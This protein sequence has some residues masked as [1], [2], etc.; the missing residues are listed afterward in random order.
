MF[1]AKSDQTVVVMWSEVKWSEVVEENVLISMQVQGDLANQI[2][3]GT[4]Y[5]YTSQAPNNT[6]SKT[7]MFKVY[8]NKMILCHKS[9]VTDN[10]ATTTSLSTILHIQ[11]LSPTLPQVSVKLQVQTPHLWGPKSNPQLTDWLY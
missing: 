6:T 7:W 10:Y 11:Y 2:R 8:Q 3:Q 9:V 5:H 1:Q 4:G